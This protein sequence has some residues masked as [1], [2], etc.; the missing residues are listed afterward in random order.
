MTPAGHVGADPPHERPGEVDP[1]GEHLEGDA[2]RR[3]YLRLTREVLPARAR[4][5]GWVVRDDHCFQR[6]L[7]DHLFG[8]VWYGHIDRPAYRHLDRAQL[9]TVV[10]LAR[11]IDAE[12]DGLLRAL[13][14]ASLR[15]RRAAR[16]G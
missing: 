15:W 12:G 8:D 10:H 2:L 3:E 9:G 1:A 13:N 14:D 16:A 5:G 7:L 11:R 4:A 6:I